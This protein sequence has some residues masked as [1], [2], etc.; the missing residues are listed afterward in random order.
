MNQTRL[1]ERRLHWQGARPCV[2]SKRAARL[3]H[4]RSFSAPN[5]CS[6][7]FPSLVIANLDS[8]IS[9]SMS[10]ASP[11]SWSATT[12]GLLILN[13]IGPRHNRTRAAISCA[14]R[15]G[16][17]SNARMRSTVFIATSFPGFDTRALIQT[18]S[19]PHG[20]SRRIHALKIHAR[21]GTA[22]RTLENPAS[23]LL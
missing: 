13:S 23:R 8:P 21:E 5:A 9:A 7:A 10:S 18:P 3:H 4:H 20:A 11:A 15:H 22:I 17:C 14:L 1:L 16:A 6:T 12:S 2:S 19:R